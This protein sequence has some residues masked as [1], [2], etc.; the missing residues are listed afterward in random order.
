MSKYPSA[1]TQCERQS[2]DR[3]AAVAMEMPAG[4]WRAG[5]RVFGSRGSARGFWFREVGVEHWTIRHTSKRARCSPHLT[6][7]HTV[8]SLDAAGLRNHTPLRDASSQLPT[9]SHATRPRN[10][11]TSHFRP[12]QLPCTSV[13]H[14]RSTSNTHPYYREGKNSF[15][16]S[17]V[18]TRLRTPQ[19]TPEAKVLEARLQRRHW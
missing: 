6:S 9:P 16:R 18:L 11:P 1:N 4:N 12:T 10:K 5:T 13:A 8:R 17:F 2:G 3:T 15:A 14:R 19:A 7:P